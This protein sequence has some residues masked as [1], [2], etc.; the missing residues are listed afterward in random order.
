MRYDSADRVGAKL[1][2]V[3]TKPEGDGNLVRLLLRRPLRRLAANGP[4]GLSAMTTA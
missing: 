1:L 3:S 2:A 4:A